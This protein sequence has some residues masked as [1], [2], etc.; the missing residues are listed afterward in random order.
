MECRGGARRAKCRRYASRCCLFRPRAADRGAVRIWQIEKPAAARS[1]TDREGLNRLNGCLCL[2]QAIDIRPIKDAVT[3]EWKAS[4]DRIMV[5][6]KR[7]ETRGRQ[8]FCARQAA[9]FGAVDLT[10]EETRFLFGNGP[11]PALRSKRHAAEARH[12]RPTSARRCGHR[13]MAGSAKSIKRSQNS[14]RL[15]RRR[16][17]ISSRAIAGGGACSHC[18]MTFCQNLPFGCCGSGCGVGLSS[19]ARLLVAPLRTASSEWPASRCRT[20]R[21]SGRPF[22]LLNDLPLAAR[23]PVLRPICSV[24]SVAWTLST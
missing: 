5:T 24:A 10:D 19:Q 17:A 1:R 12:R 13:P 20:E 18:Q 9:H 6:E 11:L 8:L 23:E 2:D 14:G 15:C 21:P 4:G 22:E 7:K 3:V 16:S